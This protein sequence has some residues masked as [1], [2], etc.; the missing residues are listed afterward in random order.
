MKQENYLDIR[1]KCIRKANVLIQKG[2]FS[3]SIQQQKIMLLLISQICP[4]DKEFHAYS[5]NILEFCRVCGLVNSGTNYEKIKNQIKRM[6][7]MVVWLKPSDRE[8]TLRIRWLEQPE[9]SFDGG[10]VD[11][12]LNERLKPYLLGLKRNFTEY[13]LIYTLAF[14]SK[15]SIRLYELICSLHYDEMKEYKKNISLDELREAIGCEGYSDFRAFRRRVLDKSVAEINE[16]SDK[17][18]TY[19]AIMQGRK[20]VSVELMISAKDSLEAARIYS[21]IEHEL[22]VPE[23]YITVWDELQAKGYVSKNRD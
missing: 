18:V 4:H 19:T 1:K 5:F 15:Y 11:L 2:R 7:D 14:R 16:H 17:T 6:C 22:G 21:E 3:L 8:G 20:I 12:C 9:I 23:G 13:P 10:T